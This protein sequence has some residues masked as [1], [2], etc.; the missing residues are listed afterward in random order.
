ME[1]KEQLRLH[2]HLI[3]ATHWIYMG[4]RATFMNYKTHLSWGDTNGPKGSPI[5]HQLWCQ[6]FERTH[7]C[8][9]SA[10]RLIVSMPFDILVAPSCILAP[11]FC[12]PSEINFNTPD[13]DVTQLER[14]WNGIYTQTDGTSEQ[15]PTRTKGS[16]R[17]AALHCSMQL[18]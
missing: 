9:E 7:A 17:H 16:T 2:I 15:Q 8:T 12:S 6:N 18:L 4:L 1:L 13:S 5:K 3:C 14:Q 11:L 10:L